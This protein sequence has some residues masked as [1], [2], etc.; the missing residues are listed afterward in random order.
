[1][2]IQLTIHDK[3][4]IEMSESSGAKAKQMPAR[5]MSQTTDF[6]L[7]RSLD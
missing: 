7:E 4:N 1:M 3:Q 5:E 6:T 2:G